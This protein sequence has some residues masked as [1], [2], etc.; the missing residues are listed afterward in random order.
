MKTLLVMRHAKSDWN[1]DYG[2]DHERPLND[3][4]VRSARIMGR[5][6]TDN[7]L[8]P[9]L[10]MTSTA[11]RARSTATL[12]NEAGGW[13]S[14]IELEPSLYGSGAES[15]I[16]VTAAAPDVARLMLIGHQPTWSM[17]VSALT[18]DRVEMKTATVAAIDFEVEA[19]RDIATARGQIA[20]VFQPRDYRDTESEED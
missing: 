17:L 5:V 1:A 13:G 15:A 2:A 12:A 19:W 18:G 20:A 16:K 7:G 4:G 8:V 3:R 9:D 14:K 6:L 10:V 11:V